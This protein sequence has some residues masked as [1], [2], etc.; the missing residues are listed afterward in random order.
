MQS[1][2]RSFFLSLTHSF[3]ARNL[4]RDPSSYENLT[5]TPTKWTQVKW[6]NRTSDEEEEEKA[7]LHLKFSHISLKY[8][9]IVYTVQF[10]LYEYASGEKRGVRKLQRQNLVT[11][12]DNNNNDNVVD[13]VKAVC[14]LLWSDNP[15]N[16]NSTYCNNF[17]AYITSL[18][19]QYPSVLSCY[20]LNL[21]K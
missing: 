6:T 12:N 17:F 8:R 3:H 20:Y 9:S 4:I 21:W 19:K 7:N 18:K 5:S 11:K 1:L 13:L 10:A 14:N 2:L 15:F 16:W